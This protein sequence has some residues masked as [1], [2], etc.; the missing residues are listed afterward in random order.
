MEK[1]IQKIQ[2][3]YE[4]SHAKTEKNEKEKNKEE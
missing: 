1:I 3:N 2:I 4:F